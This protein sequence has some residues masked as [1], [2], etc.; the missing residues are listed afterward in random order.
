MEE[1][2]RIIDIHQPDDDGE[3]REC[4]TGSPC[5]TYLRATALK[6]QLSPPP[7]LTGVVNPPE[8]KPW[9][10]AEPGTVWWLSHMRQTRV[11]ALSIENGVFKLSP[12]E[13]IAKNSPSILDGEQ[14]LP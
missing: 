10:G 9:E 6:E 11:L 12:G 13:Y 7:V 14:L 2:D 4:T 3:C 5:E 1:L 8:P